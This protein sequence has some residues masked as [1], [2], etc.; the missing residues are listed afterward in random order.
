MAATAVTPPLGGAP[1]AVEAA[2]ILGRP[3]VVRI[4]RYEKDLH[5]ALM[6][7]S[8]DEIASRDVA[9]GE[10]SVVLSAPG[11]LAAAAHQV[12]ATYSRGTVTETLI[13]PITFRAP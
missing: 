2:Q 1:I 7:A 13:R 5:V 9:P 8:T 4:E 6:G 10:S 3:V 11:A 12:V